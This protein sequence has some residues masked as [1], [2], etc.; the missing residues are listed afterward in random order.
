MENLIRKLISMKDNLIIDKKK[1]SFSQ[2]TELSKINWKEIWCR[3]CSRM[4][5]KI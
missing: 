1:I 5:R 4:Y 3:Y 2:E